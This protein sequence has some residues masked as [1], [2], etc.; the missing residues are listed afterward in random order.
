MKGLG[1]ILIVLGGA[2]LVYAL[3]MDTTVVVP[4][5][6]ERVSNL[7]LM[8]QRRNVLIVSGLVLLGG[9]IFT[10]MAGMSSRSQIDE[11]PRKSEGES[12]KTI[13]PAKGG[14]P[15]DQPAEDDE[16]CGVSGGAIL[17]VAGVGL[18]AFLLAAWVF[19]HL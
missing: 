4:G 14:T 9:F 10:G 18:A 2:G 6:S 11:T 13:S 17:L 19:A 15:L 1:V 16:S 5:Q 3:R 12:Q 7:G 8:D